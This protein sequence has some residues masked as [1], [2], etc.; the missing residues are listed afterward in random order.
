M[1]CFFQYGTQKYTLN[2]SFGVKIKTPHVQI[3][4]SSIIHFSPQPEIL[5]NTKNSLYTFNRYSVSGKFVFNT[6]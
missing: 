3:S 6:D 2:H 4:A 1:V 5:S